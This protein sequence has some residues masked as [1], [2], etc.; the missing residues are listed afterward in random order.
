MV[1]EITL[2]LEALE[3]TDGITFWKRENPEENLETTAIIHLNCPRK[4]ETEPQL[5]QASDSTSRTPGYLH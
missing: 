1:S 2:K 3:N 4:I 5:G